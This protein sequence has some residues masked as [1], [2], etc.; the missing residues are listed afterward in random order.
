MINKGNKKNVTSNNKIGLRSPLLTIFQINSR[1]LLIIWYSK[2]HFSINKFRS[3]IKVQK[4]PL[5]T[6]A[7]KRRI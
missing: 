4:D 6:N 5:L 1:K 3:L 2:L 7:E